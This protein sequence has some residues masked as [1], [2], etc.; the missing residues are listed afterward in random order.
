[1][2]TYKVNWKEAWFSF[3]LYG[4]ITVSVVLFLSI[5]VRYISSG[6]DYQY[7]FQ[8]LSLLESLGIIVGIW[9]LIP[10][11]MFFVALMTKAYQIR[12]E[13]NMI[14]GR[15][16]WFFKQSFHLN[17]IATVEKHSTEYLQGY[18]IKN[19]VGKKIYFPEIIEN[20]PELLATLEKYAPLGHAKIYSGRK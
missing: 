3:S 19:Q 18:L 16:Y 10:F 12:I 6:F 2:K 9:I 20:L 7:T 8:H 14:Y 1:M 17:E 13:N 11:L 5:L 4:G 15:N